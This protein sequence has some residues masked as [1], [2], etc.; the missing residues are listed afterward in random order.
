MFFISGVNNRVAARSR[1]IQLE[2]SATEA[3]R[4][5]G[6][7]HE[8]GLGFELQFELGFKFHYELEIE[9]GYE[10][11]LKFQCELEFFLFISYV[12]SSPASTCR[13]G[14]SKFTFFYQFFRRSPSSVSTSRLGNDFSLFLPLQDP[15]LDQKRSLGEIEMHPAERIGDAEEPRGDQEFA[16]ECSQE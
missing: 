15:I 12:F 14:K 5:L 4:V 11:E 9:F 8:F 7:E 2:S 16:R 1:S 3:Q 10:L 13:L 6:S